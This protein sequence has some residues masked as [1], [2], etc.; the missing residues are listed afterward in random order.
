MR[1]LASLLLLVAAALVTTGTAQAHLVQNCSKVQSSK[2]RQCQENNLAH[3]K[4]A[5][6]FLEKVHKTSIYDY[7]WHKKA[8]KWITKEIPP[9]YTVS[10]W[11]G[12]QIHYATLIGRGATLDPWPS[13]PDPIFGGGSWY[14]TVNCE[15]SGNWYD[16]PGYY[17]CG[18][19]FDPG[20]ETHYGRKFCP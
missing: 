2:V 9:V 14:D 11:A 1:R 10:Y 16:S 18:L 6:K 7:R 8:V 4:G 3:A 20:W 19:Q 12:I 5:V 15:N 17:R 13:C